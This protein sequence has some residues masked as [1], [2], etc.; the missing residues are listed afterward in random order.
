MP[1]A[2]TGEWYRDPPARP[3]APKVS[4]E[5]E[6]E[7]IDEA[8]REFGEAMARHGATAEQIAAVAPQ[9]RD[10]FRV[11]ASPAGVVVQA[12]HG[13]VWGGTTLDQA[14]SAMAY[15]AASKAYRVAQH[16]AEP[17]DLL[18][19]QLIAGGMDRERAHDLS[20]G[21]AF[22]DAD[23]RIAVRFPE[24]EPIRH[25]DFWLHNAAQKLLD[26]DAE[27]R[28]R[29]EISGIAQDPSSAYVL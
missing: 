1:Y 7:L 2:P 3:E 29:Q 4:A 26:A 28:R 25:G 21:R 19:D 9:H 22:R 18:R 14:V 27:T 13:G 12:N 15:Q 17:E 24:G 6:R 16:G 23:G 5:Q 10:R 11:H 8:V 20:R